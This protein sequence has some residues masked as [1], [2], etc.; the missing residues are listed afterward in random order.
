MYLKVWKLFFP[1]LTI[2]ISTLNNFDNN[3]KEFTEFV[4]TNILLCKCYT[5]AYYISVLN[6]L[7]ISIKTAT[8]VW[9]KPLMFTEHSRITEYSSTCSL[10]LHAHQG[11]EKKKINI[12]Q[13]DL[14]ISGSRF[15]K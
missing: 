11:G 4:P 10:R 7:N 2:K 9:K 5:F 12:L 1:S 14:Y 6:Y 8:Q 15:R 13:A 3:E